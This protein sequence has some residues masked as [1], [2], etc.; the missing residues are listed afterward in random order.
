MKTVVELLYTT[1]F[2]PASRSRLENILSATSAQIEFQSSYDAAFDGLSPADLFKCRNFSFARNYALVA[3]DRTL[4]ELR[5]NA[6]PTVAV[7]SVYKTTAM[8]EWNVYTGPGDIS[9]LTPMVRLA[10]LRAMAEERVTL[11][12]HTAAWFWE[13]K[14]NREYTNQLWQVKTLR[15]DP[16][17]ASCACLAYAVNDKSALHALYANE[18]EKTGGVFRGVPGNGIF[19]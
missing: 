14:S 18:A 1:P 2:S 3:D 16:T 9:L 13:V 11:D 12:P 5:A 19:A 4:T 7:V 17:G 8:D 15:A 6:V 10:L